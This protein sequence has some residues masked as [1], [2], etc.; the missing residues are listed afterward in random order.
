[1]LRVLDLYCGG[2]G[3]GMGYKLAGYSVTGV[4]HCK[5]P[6]Y[7]AG[8]F[9]CADALDYVIEHGKRYDIIHASPPCQGYSSHVTSRD[10]QYSRTRG[11]NEPRLIETTRAAL[12][13]T[14][15]PYVIENVMGA[16][17]AIYGNLLLCGT[18]FGLPI[19]RHRLFECSLLLPQPHHDS[20]RG[21][22]RAFAK[23][24]GWDARDMTVTGKGRRSGTTQ[25]WKEIMGINWTVTQ[26][27]LTEAIPPAYTNYIGTQLLA[28]LA[29]HIRKVKP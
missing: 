4:D 29:Q 24:R 26:A 19:T 10:S 9:I 13:A 2:G 28:Q 20:C 6:N 27:E 1:M 17:R 16:R 18:M 7:C 12:K 21:T 15:K 23:R 11:K 8:D 22:G 25:R 3:A 5:H 14:G